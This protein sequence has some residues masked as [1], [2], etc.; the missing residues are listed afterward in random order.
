MLYGQMFAAHVDKVPP[1][2]LSSL[3]DTREIRR[4]REKAKRLL[5]PSLTRSSG[6]PVLKKYTH[7]YPVLG[8]QCETICPIKADFV[9]TGREQKPRQT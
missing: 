5:T 9:Q 1:L 7:S 8:L 4:P 2:A 3:F 6:T